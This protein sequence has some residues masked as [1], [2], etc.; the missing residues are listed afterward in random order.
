MERALLG[1]VLRAFE[2]GINIALLR[3]R[4]IGSRTWRRT[5]SLGLVLILVLSGVVAAPAPAAAQVGELVSEASPHEALARLQREFSAILSLRETPDTTCVSVMV[6]DE[7]VFESKADSALIPASVMKIVTAAAALDVIG[8]DGVYTTEVV[9]DAEVWASSGDGV[10]E[11]NLYLVGGGDP[12]LS[13]PGYFRRYAEPVAYTDVSELADGVFQSLQAKGITRIEGG[14]VGDDSWFPDR[15]RDYA[16]HL[17]SDGDGVVWKRSHVSANQVGP[18]SGLLLN[19]G[20]YSFSWSP[21][22]RRENRR[23]SDP[24][25]HAASAFD[26]LLEARG[27]VI[28]ERPRA[29]MAPAESATLGQINSPPMSEIVER[30]L[31]RSDNT[32]AE[33]V[34]KEIGRR[35]LGSSRAQAVT[36]VQEVIRRLLGDL[37][38]DLRIVDGSG[39]SNHNRLTCAAVAELLRGAGWDSPLISALSVAGERG[40]LRN[41][42]PAAPPADQG[43]PNP[44]AAKTGY[45]DEATALAGAASTR[46]GET[47]T[48][49][50]IANRS[51][52]IGLL[53]CNRLQRTLLNAAAQYT[54]GPIVSPQ[55]TAVADENP[56]PATDTGSS[57]PGGTSGERTAGCTRFVD[58]VG[59]VHAGAIE[60]L[61]GAG[62]TLGCDVVGPRFC[63]DRPVSRAEMASLLVRALSL[64]T[65]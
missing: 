27:I 17:L 2:A 56:C 49:A 42:R 61:A 57:Q 58:V 63:P 18:L 65:D 13:T 53:L 59:G 4:T 36:G 8:E 51:D 24:P 22:R 3:A 31:S 62:V 21:F 6:N 43:P 38:D 7:P 64:D 23:T 12:V 9:V 54:Y 19:D 50:M 25:R 55:A 1:L 29:G 41:C 15:E 34:L 32:T 60:A 52:Y 20:F 5:G 16:D 40:T 10:L 35:T 33:M 45:L 44:V 37:G 30:M 46:D 47:L 39:L 14:V 26:D 48:F 28:T 11:G